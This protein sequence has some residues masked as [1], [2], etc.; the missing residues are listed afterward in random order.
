MQKIIIAI[1]FDDTIAK[2]TDDFIPHE[3]LPNAKEVINWLH[4]KNCYIIVWTCRSDDEDIET[5]ENF[6]D[7][8]DIHYDEINENYPGLDFETS[9]K[10]Y[11][12]ILIDDKTLEPIDWLKIKEKM[13]EYLLEK[14]I[15]SIMEEIEFAL[16]IKEE[17]VKKKAQPID[18]IYD[19]PQ[20][21]RKQ[22]GEDQ[23]QI[24]DAIDTETDEKVIDEILKKRQDEKYDTFNNNPSFGWENIDKSSRKVLKQKYNAKAKGFVSNI[25]KDTIANENFRKVLYTGKHTQLVLMTLQPKEDIGEEVHPDTDQF[26]RVDSGS[27]E[28]VINGKTSKISDGFAIVIPAG[29]KHNVIN[30]GKDKLKVYSLYS[31]PHHEDAIVHKTK[32]DALKSKEK[33]DGKTTE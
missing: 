19:L 22:W 8:N 4:T 10:I 33:F 11:Y 6:L 28:V 12:D 5:V 15:D 21:M 14:T 24:L 25:E 30:T 7:M 1:D 3:L 18:R 27:G 29:A 32:A 2:K 31:P 9:R 20:R 13:K 23:L 16:T 26:F 17:N